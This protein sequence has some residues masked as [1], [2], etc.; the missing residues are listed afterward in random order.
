VLTSWSETDPAAAFAVLG[1]VESTVT[2]EEARR[3]IL[4]KWAEKDP[5]GALAQLDALVPDLKAGVLGN[6]LVTRLAQKIGGKDREQVL[7]WL[8]TLPPQFRTAPA[9][10]IARQWAGKEPVAAL[11][12]CMANGVDPARGHRDGFNSWGA[13]V[14]GEAMAADPAKTVE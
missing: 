5:A 4:D 9:I 10:A 3:Q 6:E 7:A 8:A 14:L 13:G 11:E 1:Q 12:W 2:R